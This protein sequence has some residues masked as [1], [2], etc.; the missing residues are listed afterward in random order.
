MTTRVVRLGGFERWALTAV[1]LVVASLKFM[2]S[3]EAPH[4]GPASLD[5]VLHRAALSMWV[6]EFLQGALLLSPWWRQGALVGVIAW[7][8]VAGAAVAAAVLGLPLDGCGCLGPMTVTA[9]GRIS[10]S[11]GLALLSIRVAG[12]AAEKAS[13]EFHW[14]Q[15]QDSA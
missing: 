8:G 3:E 14:F 1:V 2:S 5:E 9:A 13:V 12:M 10:I 6:L 7:S 11:G 15:G 4:V